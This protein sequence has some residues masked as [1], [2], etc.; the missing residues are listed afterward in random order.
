MAELLPKLQVVNRLP[1]LR[2]RIGKYRLGTVSLPTTTL[3]NLLGIWQGIHCAGHAKTL[4]GGKR[5][6][7]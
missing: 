3:Q 7:L 5:R 6:K 4:P 2:I 1:T